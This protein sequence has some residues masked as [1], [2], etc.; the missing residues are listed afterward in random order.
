MEPIL[1]AGIVTVNLALVTYG[2]GIVTEQRSRRITK[3]VLRFLQVGVVLD[4]IATS[5]MIIG[6][7]QGL[8]LHG[9]IGFS[10]LAAMLSELIVAWRHRASHGS[11]EVPRWLHRWS[12]LTYGWWCVAYVAGAALVMGG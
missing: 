8:S 9:Y 4:I 2:I 12:R 1:I 10:A 11:A 7:G 5:F 3:K 6:S